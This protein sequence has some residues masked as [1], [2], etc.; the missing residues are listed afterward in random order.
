[1]CFV[2]SCKVV[3]G[4]GRSSGVPIVDLG[5][6]SSKVGAVADDTTIQQASVEKWSPDA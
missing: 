3:A 1:M 6:R 2:V 5:G 4:G